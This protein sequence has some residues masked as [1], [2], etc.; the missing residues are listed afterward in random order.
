MVPCSAGAQT[1]QSHYWRVYVQQVL[2]RVEPLGY[3]FG[4]HSAPLAWQIK[5]LGPCKSYWQMEHFTSKK[6]STTT[7]WKAQWEAG[8]H[9]TSSQIIMTMNKTQQ[10]I[11]KHNAKLD[12]Q[13]AKQLIILTQEKTTTNQK[14][15]RKQG[16]VGKGWYILLTRIVG[17]WAD[18]LSVF[19][20]V[21]KEAIRATPLLWFTLDSN[22]CG[23]ETMVWL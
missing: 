6:E 1:A 8:K 5:Y 4:K 22:Y 20:T 9:T 2:H 16:P 14:T 12:I 23:S 13:L 3:T 11:T 18:A 7:N 17:D 10:Q 19:L 21:R 15:Q